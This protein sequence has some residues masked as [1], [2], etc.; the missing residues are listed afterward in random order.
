[1]IMRET[2]GL[3]LARRG[4]WWL[5]EVLTI[6]MYPSMLVMQ[7]STNSTENSADQSQPCC[8]VASVSSAST[9]VLTPTLSPSTDTDTAR[10]TA[11]LFGHTDSAAGAGSCRMP[12][13]SAT[14]RRENTRRTERIEFLEN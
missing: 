9:T 10:A 11:E 3:N 2:R 4:R 7:T 8:S 1:M 6:S 13:L 5:I 12:A 14:P